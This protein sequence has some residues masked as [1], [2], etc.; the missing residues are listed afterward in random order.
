MCCNQD[1]GH[2]LVTVDCIPTG[3]PIQIVIV[4]LFGG[5][6]RQM[7]PDTLAAVKHFIYSTSI[8]F[9]LGPCFHCP[10]GLFVRCLQSL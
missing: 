10:N 7:T 3:D 2:S 9:V 6:H 5:P 1:S 4:A 8:V